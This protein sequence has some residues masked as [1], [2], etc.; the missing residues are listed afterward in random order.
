[1]TKGLLD[2]LGTPATSEKPGGVQPP[3]P[4]ESA[5]DRP[6][7]VDEA[8][9]PLLVV[10]QRMLTAAQLLSQG[11]VDVQTQTVQQDIVQR[12]DEL[13]AQFEP[14]AG[15]ASPTPQAPDQESGQQSQAP[16]TARQ[17]PGRSQQQSSGPTDAPAAAQP[18]GSSASPTAQGE[19]ARVD[20]ADP[21]ALQQSVWGHLPE[22]LRTQMQSRMVEEFLPSYREQIEDYFKALLEQE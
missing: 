19:P 8:P 21:K 4:P 1:M 12:L 6:P 20:L 11:A 22:K 5:N 13:I 16:S 14:P 15:S 9:N 17:A 10:R 7:A 3:S 18:T 2:L